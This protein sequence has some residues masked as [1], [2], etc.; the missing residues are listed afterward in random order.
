[1]ADQGQVTREMDDRRSEFAGATGQTGAGAGNAAEDFGCGRQA[2]DWRLPIIGV[3]KKF[4][5][6]HIGYRPETEQT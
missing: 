1:M 6:A 3:L 2:L 5:M 4:T